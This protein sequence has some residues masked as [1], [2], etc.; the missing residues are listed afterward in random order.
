MKL[1]ES[2]EDSIDKEK[3][4]Y[5]HKRIILDFGGSQG[6]LSQTSL[7]SALNNYKTTFDRKLLYDM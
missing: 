2:L 5:I 7:D 1:N 6:I 3:V 4:L